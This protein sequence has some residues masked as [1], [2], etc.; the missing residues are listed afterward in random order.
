MNEPQ[1]IALEVGNYLADKKE[2]TAAVVKINGAL[3]YSQ[4]AFHPKT[5]EPT[6]VLIP[7]DR[8]SV[9]KQLEAAQN[10]MATFD[11]ILKDMDAAKETLPQP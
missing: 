3:Y 9:A 4:R 10:A 6:P 11:E 2:G 8:D 5:G 1:R 7:L